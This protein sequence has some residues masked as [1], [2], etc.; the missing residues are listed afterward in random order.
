MKQNVH[1][2]RVI[3]AIV[4][5][6]V[7]AGVGTTTSATA[8]P[9][10]PRAAEAAP[11]ASAVA[12]QGLGAPA[13]RSEGATAAD[14]HGLV[15]SGP[16]PQ[17]PERGAGEERLSIKPV[18]DWVKRNAPSILAGM[19]SAV[20]NGWNSFK[21]WWNGLSAWIRASISTVAQM[22]LN[23]IFNSLWNYFFG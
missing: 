16:G 18:V 13:V 3:G 10:A 2:C 1:T 4:L 15:E 12:G 7:L 17:A 21:S 6:A 11:T 19:K 23:E 9:L 8:A 22:S 20:R 14:R 5:G